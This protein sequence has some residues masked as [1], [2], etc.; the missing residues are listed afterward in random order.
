MIR[1]IVVIDAVTV[2]T[3]TALC[4]GALAVGS[5]DAVAVA[6]GASAIL[7]GVL[8]MVARPRSVVGL[9]LVAAGGVWFASDLAALPGPAG[10][11]AAQAVYL[12][13][14]FLVHATFTPPTARAGS[15]LRRVGIV[16]T[17][18][19]C[20]VPAL[21]STAAGATAWAGAYAALAVWAAVRAPVRLRRSRTVAAVAAIVL[22]LAVGGAG[23]ARAVDPGP[24]TAAASLLVY[25]VGFVIAAVLLGIGAVVRPRIEP[26]RVLAMAD[27]EG[28]LRDALAWAVDDP[29]LRLSTAEVSAMAGGETSAVGR[30]R[31]RV[32]LDDR[33]VVEIDLDETVSMD[34]AAMVTLETAV[35]INARAAM[36]RARLADQA[37]LLAQSRR[38]LLRASDQEESRVESLV[39]D[40][41]GARLRAVADL[42]RVSADRAG[43]ELTPT[44]DELRASVRAME[45]LLARV[46]TGIYPRVLDEQG[47]T[48]AVDAAARACPVPVSTE[49]RVDALAPDLERAVYYVVS[50]ALANVAKH[51]G[52]AAALVQIVGGDD[53]VVAVHDDGIGGAPLDARLGGLRDRVAA[54][55]GLLTLSGSPGG[56]TTVR[57]E[58]PLTRGR[59]VQEEPPTAMR[60]SAR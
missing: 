59:R 15:T 4:L 22:G 14:A 45:D 40:G 1:R 24:P 11:V 7:T 3:A 57:A 53:L 23:V 26:D 52:A 2:V 18:A 58:F 49:I 16:A 55:G 20:A 54:W 12:H 32:H 19:I 8:V 39:A 9:L 30:V 10:A 21:W 51:S 33:S 25:E 5:P 28:S 44:I 17:Y 31:R 56:G 34:A 36:L 6:S 13:R 50:E 41:A 46:R 35:R 27:A 37:E 60:G 38:R 48:A 42:L 47:L 43:A 29:Q